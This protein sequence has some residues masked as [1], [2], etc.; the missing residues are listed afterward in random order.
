MNK[1]MKMI[2]F[3][4]IF[5]ILIVLGYVIYSNASKNNESTLN[6]KIKSEIEYLEVKLLNMANRMNNITVQNYKVTTKEVEEQ[7]GTGESSS[8]SAES[9][10]ESQS[11]GNGGSGESEGNSEGSDSES[12]SSGGNTSSSGGEKGEDKETSKSKEYSMERIKELS[13]D[14]E[15]EINWDDI[16]KEIEEIYAVIPTITLDLYQTNINQEDILKI[17]SYLDELAI[18]AKDENEEDVLSKICD[19]YSCIT[20]FA[21]NVSDD[22]V[23]KTTIKT[24]EDVL[25]AYSKVDLDKWDE[26]VKDLQS[27][28]D[29]FSILLTNANIEY[30]KQI[31]IN[32]IYVILNELKNAANKKDSNVFFI[33]YKNLL[34]ETNGL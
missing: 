13:K 6:D 24:K 29:K 3:I 17:N 27:G 7:S 34:E 4:S 10:Q 32:R 23:Y 8:K 5:V 20:K 25:K 31:N 19:M 15:K 14:K 26:V 33:K 21:D 18:K 22:E 12:S 16:Q 9:G 1:K 11:Q 28:I 30:G 2:S